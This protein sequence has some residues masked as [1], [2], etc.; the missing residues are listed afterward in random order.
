MQKLATIEIGMILQTENQESSPHWEVGVITTN[1]LQFFS[2][3][4]GLGY[5]LK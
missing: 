2:Q 3:N 4:F 1:P 5:I